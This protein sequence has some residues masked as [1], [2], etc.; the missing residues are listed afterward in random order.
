[1]SKQLLQASVVLA[2]ALGSG[3][4]VDDV[5]VVT[6]P[7]APTGLY[8]ELEP[9]GDPARPRGIVLRWTP[10]G[11]ADLDAYRVYSRAA[12]AASFGLRGETSSPSFHDDGQPQLE[13]YVTAVSVSGGESDPS[14]VVL[15]D[16]RLRL[17]PP[18]TLVSIS[19]NGAIHLEWSDDAYRA[20]RAGFSHYRV[21][22][23][24]YDLDRNLCGASWSV[25]G[26]T[27]S[28]RFLAADLAN[29]VSRCFGV[30]AVAIEG[31]ESLWSPLRNDT[32][33]PDGRNLIVFATTADAS[34]SGFRFFLDAN[35]DGR[36]SLLEL[37]LV[38]AG[39]GTG[40]DF[41]VQRSADGALLIVPQRA[42]TTVRLYRSEP[43]ADL[44]SIDVAPSGGYA[45]GALEAV[46]RFGYVFQMDEGDGF[47]RYGALR[48][49]AVGQDYV[50]FDWA[51]QT[52]RGNPELVGSRATPTRQR[53][54]A[55]R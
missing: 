16:E 45:R 52:D 10:V 41:S 25:E 38:G 28:S 44:T 20:S 18:A 13:Y 22:S 48:V 31:F 21:F 33:R 5:T 1:V 23:S 29:G 14:N 55:A 11:D 27:V 34:R 4:C 50:I 46:P 36:A 7:S 3:G 35:N 19:L 39:P 24:S 47:Y 30:S 49:T 8:Y 53:E 37:G 32:P 54:R 2:V 15:V 26:T 40:M 6:V 12:Q 17:P 42:A 43:I 51:F 9:S